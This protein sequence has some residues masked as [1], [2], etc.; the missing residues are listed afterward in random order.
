M[1]ATARQQLALSHPLNEALILAGAL[2]PY[3]AT[4]EHATGLL[5]M[6]IL[7]VDR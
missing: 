5:I 7:A 3:T 1:T 6:T 2:G 4:R